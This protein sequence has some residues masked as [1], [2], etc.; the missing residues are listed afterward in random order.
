MVH[1]AYR[2]TAV[3][4]GLMRVAAP[5]LVRCKTNMSSGD[6]SGFYREGGYVDAG[7]GGKSHIRLMRRG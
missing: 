3:G 6:P 4:R 1:P 2:G 7:T 5:Q